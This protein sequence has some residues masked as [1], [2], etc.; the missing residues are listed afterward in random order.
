V[1]IL[2]AHEADLVARAILTVEPDRV[3]IRLPESRADS[4]REFPEKL[5]RPNT[6]RDCVGPAKGWS[7]NVREL[8]QMARFAGAT[9]PEVGINDTPSSLAWQ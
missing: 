3:R 6:V 1:Q 4:N 2:T 7:V 8:V 5:G 9:P